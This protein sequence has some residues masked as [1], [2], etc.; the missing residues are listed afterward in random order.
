MRGPSDARCHRVGPR[1][2]PL[3]TLFGARPPRRRRARVH[4]GGVC[5]SSH[6]ASHPQT[7]RPALPPAPSP[8][9]GRRLPSTRSRPDPPGRLSRG[10]QVGEELPAAAGQGEHPRR[11]VG[12]P[13][14]RRRDGPRTRSR[15]RAPLRGTR[16]SKRARAPLPLTTRGARARSASEGPAGAPKLKVEVVVT[17]RSET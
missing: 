16:P 1:P 14:A 3:R 12:V 11:L 9:S 4:G 7:R 6:L 17:L 15:A 8:P 13:A 2:G 5:R 10:V